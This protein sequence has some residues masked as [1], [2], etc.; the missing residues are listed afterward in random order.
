MRLAFRFNYIRV[1]IVIVVVGAYKQVIFRD[2]T[3]EIISEKAEL[4]DFYR[5]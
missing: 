3:R 5:I 2:E 1:Y 4:F